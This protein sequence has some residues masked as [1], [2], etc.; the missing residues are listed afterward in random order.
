MAYY[1]PKPDS[2]TTKPKSERSQQLTGRYSTQQPMQSYEMQQ[3][4]PYQQWPNSQAPNQWQPNQP[5]Y[6]QSYGMQGQAYQQS[7]DTSTQWQAPAQRNPRS[8]RAKGGKTE[9]GWRSWSKLKKAAV[10][11]ACFVLLAAIGG[12]VGSTSSDKNGM[13]ASNLPAYEVAEEVTNDYVRNGIQGKVYRVRVDQTATDEQLKAIFNEVTRQ[14]GT[15]LHC[16]FFYARDDFWVHK[17]VYDLAKLHDEQGMIVIERQ[18][19]NTVDQMQLV[20]DLEKKQQ[21]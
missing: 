1:P 12:S 5:Q 13:N 4:T 6:Q 21:T 16:I 14:D 7:T 11:V 2:A 9:K 8:K 17:E 10:I 19:Q 3:S 15:K 18:S 20:F